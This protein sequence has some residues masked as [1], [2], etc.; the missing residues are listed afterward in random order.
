MLDLRF[1]E[2]FGGV[3]NRFKTNPLGTRVLIEINSPTVKSKLIPFFQNKVSELGYFPVEL[4]LTKKTPVQNQIE[5]LI[6]KYPF[7]KIVF[8]C[9]D[10]SAFYSEF[11]SEKDATEYLDRSIPSFNIFQHSFSF[12]VPTHIF[13]S[14]YHFAP[15]LMNFTTEKVK[16]RLN[17]DLPLAAEYA[18]GSR[19]SL[20]IREQKIE[21]LENQLEE[22]IKKKQGEIQKIN[23]L[24]TLTKSYFDHQE[25]E[26]AF[27]A[28]TECVDSGMSNVYNVAYYKNQMGI[29]YHIWGRFDK[30]LEQY[31]E[32]KQIRENLNDKEG[33][34]STYHQLGIINQDLGDYSAAIDF[35]NKSKLFAEELEDIRNKAH[36]VMNIGTVYM[37]LGNLQGAFEC[38]KEAL[39]IYRKYDNQRGIAL[40]LSHIGKIQM[41]NQKFENALKYL[42]I[43]RYMYEKL[44]TLTMVKIIDTN[45]EYIRQQVGDVEFMNL[46]DSIKNSMDSRE[47]EDMKMKSVE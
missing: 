15:N 27:E 6:K 4:N 8:I 37:N 16:F 47:K 2:Q 13:D 46:R 3:F 19:Q 35:Y 34:A 9:S 17:S 31:L 22:T 38:F 20:K 40:C 1:Q 30:A 11:P 5:E 44:N 14:I 33:L 32:A 28:Y 25:Y 36:T 10:L 29:I 41:E 45:L 23:I 43:S 26:K 24:Q 21:I 18:M 42:L 39:E 12:W 7:K